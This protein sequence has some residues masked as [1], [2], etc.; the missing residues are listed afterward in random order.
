MKAMLEFVDQRHFSEIQMLKEKI[1]SVRKS[2]LDMTA[3][4]SGGIHVGSSL[5]CVDLIAT[6]YFIKMRHSPHRPGWSERDRFIL[7]KGHAAPALYAVLAEAGYFPK[8]ELL[9][10]R[11]MNSRLQGHPDLRTPGVD[12][13]SGSL[14]QGLSIGI[15]MAVAAKR[16]GSLSKVY[17]L[18]GDG[19]CDEGQ[20]WEALMTAAHMKLNNLILIID[21]N[22][23]QLDDRTEEVKRKIPLKGKLESFGWQTYMV[24]GHD[25]EK[26]LDVLDL[27]EL[28]EWPTAIIAHT[29]KGKGIQFIE[30]T[31]I[32]HKIR[33]SNEQYLAAL[34]ELEEAS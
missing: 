18:M 20:V 28:S 29:I 8:E 22:G 24:D 11:G 4:T 10:L 25:A 16:R 14:G 13:P 6:L 9:T 33:L 15:G 30:D 5:S 21:R 32:G 17:V 7:S 12:A 3:S 19:E 26:F 2:I 23:W 31:N 1:K 27:C 34:K